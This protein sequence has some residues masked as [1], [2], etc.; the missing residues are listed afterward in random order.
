MAEQQ[1]RQDYANKLPFK[2][3]LHT[4]LP[5]PDCHAHLCHIIARAD[6]DV[7]GD[8]LLRFIIVWQ[9]E[10][11]KKKRLYCTPARVVTYTSQLC[12]SITLTLLTDNR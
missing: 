12:A 6:I 4:L 11:K 10:G 8:K 5:P 3:G 7:S 9:E 1:L 2:C